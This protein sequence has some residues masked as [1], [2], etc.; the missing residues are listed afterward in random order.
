MDDGRHKNYEFI[1]EG[2]RG[3]WKWYIKLLKNVEH[4]HL[5]F[6][7]KI[8]LTNGTD[9]NF[10]NFIEKLG[11]YMLDNYTIRREKLEK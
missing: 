2:C 4:I 6:E 10:K 8:H 11:E 7:K 5:F 1:L 9:R 3:R